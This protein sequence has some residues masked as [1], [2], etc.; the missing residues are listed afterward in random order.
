MNG[1][2][3][4]N[5]P[6]QSGKTAIVTGANAGIGYAIAEALARKGARVILACRDEEKAESAR[7][8]IGDAISGPDTAFLALDLADLD[9]ACHP[10]IA[11]TDLMPHLG[12][13][14]VVLPLVGLFLNDA[15]QGAL[16][17]LQAAT[18]PDAQGGEYYGP[19][20]FVR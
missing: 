8:K 10:S 4:E 18:D 11:Q 1:F 7:Q 6:D 5:I 16:P 13:A 9:I 15:D 2:T 20:G 17:V 3:F 19:Y 12:P 14:K